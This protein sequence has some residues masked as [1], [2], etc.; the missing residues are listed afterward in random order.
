MTATVLRERCPAGSK[1][2]DGEVKIANI[3]EAKPGRT[4][5]RPEHSIDRIG[6][7]NRRANQQH[8]TLE[9]RKCEAD[10]RGPSETACLI[11]QTICS[12]RGNGD[13]WVTV[14][15]VSV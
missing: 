4:E 12:R 13:Q 14:T 5:G 15:R 11:P 8:E 3:Q 6:K 7:V 2:D 1:P 10:G 9:L